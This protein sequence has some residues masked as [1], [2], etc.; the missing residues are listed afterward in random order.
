MKRESKLKIT[1][2]VISIL[3]LFFLYASEAPPM[4]SP[5]NPEFIRYVQNVD[6][7][8][9]SFISDDG[10]WLG[11][12]PAPVDL[13]H[14]RNVDKYVDSYPAT[15]DL[16][17]LN[18][19]TPIKNQGGCGS[20]WTFATYASLESYGKP[21]NN[22]NFSEQD[23][24]TN[25]GF[26]FPE[27]AGGHEFMST[28]Y[29][30][31]WSGPLSESDVPYPYGVGISE[32]AGYSPQKHVQQVVFLP[33]RSTYLDND[34]IKYFVTNYGAVHVSFYYNGAYMDSSDTNY[35]CY[36]TTL[37][38]HAVAVVG[39]DDN[40]SKYNFKDTPPGN[41]AFII[42]N[43]WGTA[44]HDNGYFYL[45][46]YDTSF[47]P[48]ASFN[49]AESPNNY[50]K[51]YQYDPLGWV[52][53]YGY[54]DTDAW[55]A[56]IFTAEDNYPLKAVSFYTNDVNTNYTIYV[57]KGVSGS[58]PRSGV[59]AAT[60]TGSQSYPGYYTV[61][62]DSPVPLSNGV[63]FSVVIEFSNTSFTYPV[64]IESVYGGYSSAASANPGESY[65][66]NSGTYW[67]DL[68]NEGTN[69]CIKAFAS[70]I[71]LAK[72]DFN[73]DGYSD[74]IWRYYDGIYGYNALWLKG[75]V[76]AGAGAKSSVK[77]SFPGINPPGG[78]HMEN[79]EAKDVAVVDLDLPL[80]QLQ[81]IKDGF[82]GNQTPGGEYNPEILFHPFDMKIKSSNQS[83]SQVAALVVSDPRDD[84]QA[85]ELMAVA[86]QNWKIAGTADFNID[87]KEDIVW[88]N[89]ST[90][91]N[92]VWY[93]NGTEMAGFDWLPTG[94]SADWVLG[95]IVDFNNDG[96]PDL[97]WHN[98]AD[99]RNGVWYL[100]GVTVLPGG[101]VVMT[102]GASLDWE[103]CGTGDF[104][105]DG[106]V[107]LVWRNKVDGRNGV[108]YMDGPEM[109][110]V[111]WLPSV[112]DQN[113][114]IRGTGDFD[115]DGKIDLI[116][117][118]VSDGR[119]TIWYLDGITVTGYEPLTKVTDT[120]WTIEN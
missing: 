96:K 21:S 45:S 72:A 106:Q 35:Y 7:V 82:A 67:Y 112:A 29:L 90:R 117:R 4:E 49:H 108:W 42:R 107:D 111:G 58:D 27:C 1:V 39:W 110:S 9:N 88:S 97:I 68:S 91:K 116:W 113:W 18:K 80:L 26:D 69:V 55:G 54:G 44:R 40:Y 100:D 28:A 60:K 74:I 76:V 41:G 84:P 31:R 37:T 20:C 38:N 48:G 77:Q 83:L 13:S 89:I 87:G 25:H 61:E 70:D 78:F 46:Y 34:T 85:V 79:M 120:V 114:E 99:G 50:K 53:S 24:N 102:T 119:N 19:L 10:Y 92:C 118:N 5:M 63:K 43:S 109:S 30:A 57:Y 17:T 66:S 47:S 101:Y 86:D 11:Y 16:R 95:G 81:E 65:V 64:P 23:L 22:W 59:L 33:Q 12:I 94:A 6:R 115:G 104:N 75:V 52:E 62:L 3:S 32:A 14:I 71:Q 105:N 56:N 51:I 103:L 73:Q 98:E 15:Y 36:T 8:G 2:M 93:M